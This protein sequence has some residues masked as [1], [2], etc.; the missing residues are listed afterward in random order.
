MKR[1]VL[2]FIPTNF[3][4]DV[5][6]YLPMIISIGLLAVALF[7]ISSLSLE[8]FLI[9]SGFI[10]NKTAIIKLIGVGFGINLVNFFVALF[11][12]ERDRVVAYL[13]V[14]GGVF[15]SLV[16]CLKVATILY[17]W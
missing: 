3:D 9:V 12:L 8:N 2:G 6:L 10:G 15:V 17:F 11:L 5:W 7:L 13:L 4:Q 14:M 1:R 16:I